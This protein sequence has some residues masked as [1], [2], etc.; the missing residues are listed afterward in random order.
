MSFNP[1]ISEQVQEVVS[2]EKVL[3]ILILH[4]SLK[5][6]LWFVHSLKITCVYVDEKLNIN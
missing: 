1:G 6:H 5:S 3:T 2:Q 4:C